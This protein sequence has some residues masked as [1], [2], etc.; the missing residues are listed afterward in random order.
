MCL[1]IDSKA[2]VADYMFATWLCKRV[3]MLL[4]QR[5]VKRRLQHLDE[6]VD[7]QFGLPQ[8]TVDVR[9]ALVM[10]AQSLEVVKVGKHFAIQINKRLK[11]PSTRIPLAAICRL[12]SYGSLTTKGYTLFTDVFSQVA[13]RLNEYYEEY[14]FEYYM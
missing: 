5:L 1:V 9:K 10:S 7:L 12:V 3:Q 11:Y 8:G 4:M 6:F 13:D 2:F 14:V